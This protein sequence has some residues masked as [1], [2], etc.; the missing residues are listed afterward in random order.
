MERPETMTEITSA[1]DTLVSQV[2]PLLGITP[3]K[4]TQLQSRNTPEDI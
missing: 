2:T 3:R 1:G 4:N